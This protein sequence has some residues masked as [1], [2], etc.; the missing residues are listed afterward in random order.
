MLVWEENIFRLL[1]AVL[2]S[3]NAETSCV[4]AQ[5]FRDPATVDALI[6]FA[7]EERVCP[8]LHEAVTAISDKL[9]TN[10][11]RHTLAQR[12]EK[13]LRRNVMIRGILL[14]LA[15]TGALAGIEF[16]AL[17]GAAWLSE[18][19]TNVAAWRSLLDI[20]V[21]VAPQRFNEI[22]NLL[23]RLGYKRASDSKRFRNN[24][25]HAPYWKPST[26]VTIEVHR[27]LGWQYNLLSP[28]IVFANAKRVVPGLLQP[29]P[30]CRA[31]HAIAH[32]QIQ[33]HGFSRGS[34]PVKEVLEISRFLTRPDVDWSAVMAHARAVG[35][36]EACEAATA[37]AATLLSAPVPPEIAIGQTA[38][39]HVRHS[40]ARRSSAISMWLA[41]QKWRAGTLWRC[42]KIAYRYFLRG[43]KPT[44]I[45]FAVWI[46]RI[47]RMPL[48]AARAVAIGARF[49]K[50]W[51]RQRRSDGFSGS[52]VQ[53][54]DKHAPTFVERSVMA[55]ILGSE[56]A[57]GDGHGR[58]NFYQI[59][60]LVI[61]SEFAIP[62]LELR[63]LKSA[64]AVDVEI[65]LGRIPE[66]LT[67]AAKDRP[68]YAENGH[69]LLT[70]PKIARYRVSGGREVLVE[71]E[72]DLSLVRLFLLGSVM[73]LVCQQRG[74]LALHASAVAVGHEAVAFVGYQG[75]GKSTL[76]AHCLAHGSV[77]LVTD[78]ILV[79]TFDAGGRPWAHPGM[80][81]VK[82]WRDA[83][84]SLGHN[85]DG[86]R[87][88]W[89]R[90]DKFLLPIADQLIA[91]PVRLNRVYVLDDDARP[92]DGQIDA[93][94]GA[95]A[96]AALVANTYRG[97]YLDATATRPEHFSFC[98]RLAEWVPVRRLSRRR[99]LPRIGS[100]AAMV[101]ADFT[102]T[103]EVE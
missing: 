71:P 16:V 9:V 96:A 95:A 78:D 98:A 62:E 6:N 84:Q 64:L 30:W 10:A 20:D 82:L 25:H 63:R 59:Y 31:F 55:D 93:L 72:A 17:K 57:R 74:L 46:G 89:I 88:D 35:A 101:L 11:L 56:A 75:Q 77:R 36:S 21:L 81:A 49:A 103:L 24:F 80:P 8:A 53:L 66:A 58:H 100:T 97:E 51:L 54:S 14:E 3:Q 43:A 52:K 76:A 86:L 12:W 27:H 40:L 5:A 39:K 44:T 7:E 13:N 60:G 102:A 22:P 61:S 33:D 37:L 69:A 38:R 26:A 4:D 68:L 42:E 18:D 32:W 29:A 2:A 85:A 45:S 47:A 1:C 28:E 87:P 83:L 48:L 50:L 99:N 73:G 92:G 23:L 65:V 67:A 34:T 41:T 91:S 15:E 90:A 94:S 19:E 70:I 79:V